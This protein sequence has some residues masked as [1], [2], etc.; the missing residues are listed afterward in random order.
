MERNWNSN[1]TIRYSPTWL[2]SPPQDW[3]YA[4]S[5]WVECPYATYQV[6]FATLTPLYWSLYFVL[7]HQCDDRERYSSPGLFGFHPFIDRKNNYYGMIGTYNPT[8]P[9]SE[10]ITLSDLLQPQ[11]LAALA[12][13][14]PISSPSTP[15]TPQSPSAP[16]VPQSPSTPISQPSTST[17]PTSNIGTAVFFVLPPL[18]CKLIIFFF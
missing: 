16:N 8:K 13:S 10:S 6:R 15:N 11:I 18:L 1:T 12:S 9:Y 5:F 7:Y 14:S 3:R 4:A 17:M 2:I